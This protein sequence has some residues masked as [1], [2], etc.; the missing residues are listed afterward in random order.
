MDTYQ[1][2]DGTDELLGKLS[3]GEYTA[4]NR[5]TVREFAEK[6]WLPSV[7]A[8]VAGGNMRPSTAAGYRI[9]VDSYVVPNLGSVLLRDL[10]GPMLNKLY[11]QLLVSGRKR[12]GK[13][14]PKGLSPTSVPHGARD[15]PPDAQ[16]R[17]AVGPRAP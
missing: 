1:I 5:L 14:G 7:Q 17:R 13:D 11:G 10:S 9:Q 6:Q 12:P 15:D 3:K 16:G 8:L 4:P 2:Y